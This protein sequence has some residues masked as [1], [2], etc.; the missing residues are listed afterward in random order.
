MTKRKRSIETD[1]FGLPIGEERINS[2][3][4]GDTNERQACKW[5]YLWTGQRFV[6]TPSS[7]G[8]RLENASNF[9]GDV[10]CENEDFN[11]LFAVETKHLKSIP[12]GEKLRDNSKIFT[13]WQQGQRDA[14]RAK[15]KCMLMLR[16]NGMP[17]GKYYIVFDI[18][19][20]ASVDLGLTTP[21]FIGFN[22]DLGIR[23]KGYDS[24]VVLE[25]LGY[26]RFVV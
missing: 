14:I 22:S 10:V 19:T 6:R 18:D 1:I 3:L 12:V 13:I 9:C 21:E 8:R 15:R 23:I 5:L 26:K 2:K 24:D 25:K 16:S 11:F 17:K 7:G 4:K 20:V